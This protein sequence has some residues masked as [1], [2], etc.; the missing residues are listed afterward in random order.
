LKLCWLCLFSVT[1]KVPSLQWCWYFLNLTRKE[2]SY[3]DKRFWVSYI[4]FIIIIGGILVLF[5]YISRLA[6]N[7]IFS[8]S[9][10]IHR[11]VG[12]A[13]DLSAPFVLSLLRWVIP[14]TL[15]WNFYN[16]HNWKVIQDDIK[17]LPETFRT[18]LVFAFVILIG[19][20]WNI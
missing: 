14:F 16:G 2:T 6:S 3:S 20:L 4:L 10:K 15:K 19:I 7:E 8:P 18:E 5:I 11:E 9:N 1:D 13:K 17:L 12:R